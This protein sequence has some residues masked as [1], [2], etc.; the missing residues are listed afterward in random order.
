MTTNNQRSWIGKRFVGFLYTSTLLFVGFLVANFMGIA[1]QYGP[2]AQWVSGIYGAYLGGQSAT[3][4]VKAK[5]G[6]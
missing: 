3:D 1:E 4:Y 6:N 2:F 5:N